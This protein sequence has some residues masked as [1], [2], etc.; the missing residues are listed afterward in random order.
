MEAVFKQDFKQEVFQKQRRSQLI[1]ALVQFRKKYSNKKKSDE[2]WKSKNRLKHD[3]LDLSPLFLMTFL[4]LSENTEGC[5]DFNLFHFISHVLLWF[6]YSL[7]TIMLFLSYFF[8]PF[9]FFVS[10]TPSHHKLSLLWIGSGKATL[11]SVLSSQRH[12]VWFACYSCVCGVFLQSMHTPKLTVN[13]SCKMDFL[14][15]CDL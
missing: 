8:L 4:S 13:L 2:R 7:I 6:I 10:L 1:F 15:V 12:F 11:Q 14:F 9:V 5:L 3:A